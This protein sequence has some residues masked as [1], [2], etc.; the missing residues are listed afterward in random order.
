MIAT[1]TIATTPGCGLLKKI[2]DGPHETTKSY[3]DNYGLRIEYPEV[4]QCATP[5]TEA[6]KQAITPMALEDPSQL[7]VYEIS[8]EEAVQQAV[9]QSPVLRRIGGSVVGTPVS[10][11]GAATVYDPALTASS[12][13]QGTEAALSAFD[14]QWAQQLFWSNVDQPQNRLPFN[15]GTFVVASVAQRSQASYF[16]ELAKQTATGATFS[17]RHLVDYAKTRDSSVNAQLFPSAYSGSVEAEYR[18]PLLQGAGVTYNRIAGPTQQP[19]VYNG[20]L[21]ARLNEDVALADFESAVIA[22]VSDVE[23]AYWD[24]VTAYRILDTQVRGRQA[25][26]QT[27]QY[28]QVRL[29]VGTGR[30]DEEAQARSQFY[31]FQAQVE[32]ALG[33][34]NGLYASEQRLRYLIGLTATDGR[35]L[36]PTTELIDAKVIFDWESALAQSLD[37]RIEIRRQRFNVKRRELEIVAARLNL[38]PRL[39]LLAQWRV[40]GLGDNLLGNRAYRNVLVPA[41]TPPGGGPP[42]P[43]IPTDVPLDNLYG[44]ITNGDFQEFQAGV[45]FSMPVGLR[46]ASLAVTNARLGLRRERALLAETELRVSHD[47]SEAARQIE[48]THKLMDTNY[49]RFQADLNQVEVLRKRYLEGNDNINFL[50]Q[51]QRQVVQSATQFYQSLSDYNLSIRDFHRQKGSLL[52][53]NHVQLAEDAWAVGASHDAYQ[54]GRFLKPKHVSENTDVPIPLTRGPFDPS[55]PQQTQG[56]I[57][58]SVESLPAQYDPQRDLE[59]IPLPGDDPQALPDEAMIEQDAQQIEQLPQDL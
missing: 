20:V 19:G 24:L 17:L 14:A 16:G 8:L 58:Y 47:L 2:P 32:V 52:A 12:T 51:A 54:T 30:S 28:Q 21:I 10:L 39:D 1:T 3:H 50:L 7:P 57:D 56:A 36:K 45:E 6:A 41:P 18:Q 35:L 38:R 9:Q 34:V 25:A 40:R 42:G 11:G 43:P 48:V 29:E 5:Q 33:G 23:Q 55:A 15:A 31:Q 13:S 4:A 53:Y 49:N 22:L 44:S 26:L 59:A 37:R 27:F 46:L